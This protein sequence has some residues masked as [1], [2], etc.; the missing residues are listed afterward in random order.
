MKRL[1]IIL[2]LFI[3]APSVLAQG[4][5]APP[6]PDPDFPPPQF[7]T[8]LT[9]ALVSVPRANL[10]TAPSTTNSV[11]V[12]IAFW[13]ERYP[14]VGAFYPGESMV[15]DP[16]T[17]DFVF[18]DPDEREVWY[19]L[20][21][22][23]GEV[24]IFGGLVL[25]ANPDELPDFEAGR[26]LTPEEQA[27]LDE[28]LAFASGTLALRNNARLRNGPG[29]NFDVITIAPYASRVAVIGRN[30]FGTWVLVDY[31]GTQ[32]W[33]SIYLLAAPQGYDLQAVP[34]VP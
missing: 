25:I 27:R 28:Q 5:P 22:G 2:L 3:V 33:V 17:A 9:F 30:A 18:D 12:D 34:V 15:I 1:V 7:A 24:W 16:D 11:V 14:I 23:S 13:G 20:D 21:V 19:L 6:D 32:G 10:R 4:F 8:E 26:E 31:N 29:T